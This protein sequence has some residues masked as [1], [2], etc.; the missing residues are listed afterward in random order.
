MYIC[1]TEKNIIWLHVNGKWSFLFR[2][3]K[4]YKGYTIPLIECLVERTK[5]RSAFEYEL[6]SKND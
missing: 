4:L 3:E 6:D 1:A 5:S 2:L